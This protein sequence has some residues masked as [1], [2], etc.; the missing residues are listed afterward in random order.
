MAV[1]NE[2]GSRPMLTQHRCDGRQQLIVQHAGAVLGGLL[3]E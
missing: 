3:R 1:K 2:G